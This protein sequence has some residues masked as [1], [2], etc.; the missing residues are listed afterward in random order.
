MVRRFL[1]KECQCLG[2]S[3]ASVS[4]L[5]EFIMTG[6]VSGWA[7]LIAGIIGILVGPFLA[8][9]VMATCR[10]AKVWII[11]RLSGK[12]FQWV[13]RDKELLARIKAR[14][15]LEEIKADIESNIRK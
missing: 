4:G 12:I 5:A 6:G 15:Y 11:G 10:A 9:L 13:F 14:L 7:P 1:T 2:V 8:M 3:V